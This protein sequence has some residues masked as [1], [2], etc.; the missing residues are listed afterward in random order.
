[1]TSAMGAVPLPPG[2][3]W[4]FGRSNRMD[5]RDQEGS[6]FALLFAM[7]LVYMLMAALFESFSHP[8]AIMMSVP[9]A[10]VGVGVMMKLANQPRD[11]F[12]ELGFIVLVGVVV[13]NAIVLIDHVNRLRTEGMERREAIVRGGRDRLRAIAMTAITTI[14]GLLPM[15]APILLPQWFGPVEGRAGTW[16]PVG[17][18]ILGG[19]TTSTFLTLLIVPTLYS[20]VDD[21]AVFCRKVAARVVA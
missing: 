2:Y 16:A 21:L 3:S 4:S 7:V 8:F 17:L 12:T 9:F 18:V 15:V 20:V 11:N 14:V 10:F 19:L 1:V 5:Q 13:N 6:D